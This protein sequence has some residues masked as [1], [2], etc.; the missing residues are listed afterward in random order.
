MSRHRIARMILAGAI[1]TAASTVIANPAHAA[2]P[3]CNTTAGYE[4]PLH[5][6]TWAPIPVYRS[7]NNAPT[8]RCNLVRGTNGEAVK[9]LQ[10]TI[11]NCFNFTEKL[12]EDGDF[13]GRTEALL[14][15][16]Q[17]TAGTTPDGKYG[18]NTLNAFNYGARWTAHHNA[19]GWICVSVIGLE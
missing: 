8:A 6:D 16:A 5:L 13:G 17:S 15:A 7:G 11:N 9:A 14:K 19:Y 18:W 1:A 2:T 10:R 12:R 4:S 3:T